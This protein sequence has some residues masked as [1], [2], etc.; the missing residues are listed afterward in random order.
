MSNSQD[1]PWSD[2]P[3]AP[4]ISHSLYVSEKAIFAGHFLHS[5]LYGTSKTHHPTPVYPRSLFLFG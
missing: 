5:I 2:N 4:K 1:Q 3:N